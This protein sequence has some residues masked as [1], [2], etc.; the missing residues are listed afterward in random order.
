MPLPAVSA[1]G[2]AKVHDTDHYTIAY[3]AHS[4]DRNNVAIIAEQQ[5]G[6]THPLGHVVDVLLGGG[7]CGFQPQGEEGS[8][9]EDDLDLYDWAEER[10]WSIARN[11]SQFNDLEGGL[12]ETRLPILGTFA[13]GES[14]P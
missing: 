13:D 3:S 1:T 5:V 9:R 12:G 4:P 10:G 14:S 11:R 2:H 6:K 7:R 8:C